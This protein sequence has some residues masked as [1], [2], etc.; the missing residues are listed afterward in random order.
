[1]RHSTVSDENLEHPVKIVY[2]NYR[3][4]TTMRTIVPERVWFGSTEWH[5]EPQWLLEAL[6][7]EKGER[8]SFAMADIRCWFDEPVAGEGKP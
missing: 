3:H 1:M 2:T 8:R 6:D 4:Q 7:V 5:P